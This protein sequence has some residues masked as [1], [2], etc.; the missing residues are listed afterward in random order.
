MEAKSPPIPSLCNLPELSPE[1][2]HKNILCCHHLR[3]RVDR[4][5]L[6]WLFIF[7]DRGFFR[8]IHKSTPVQYVMDFLKYQDSEA[9]EVVRVAR[10]LPLLPKLG[11]AFENG[12][13]SWSHLKLISSVAREETEEQWLAFRKTHRPGALRAEVKNAIEKGRTRPRK[14]TRG[15]PNTTVDMKFRFTLEEM[16]LARQAL[17]LAASEM[18]AS[19]DGKRPTP[20]QVLLHL[21]KRVL[22]ADMAVKSVE[23]SGKRRSIYQ[24]IY[25]KCPDCTQSHIL[26]Q[27][28]PVE[29]SHEHVQKIEVEAEK[30][31]I[32]PHELVK[33]EALTPGKANQEPVPA[34]VERKVMARYRHS[35]VIC[36]R[37]GDLHIHHLMFRSRGGGNEL[38]NLA[39]CC[40]PCHASVHDGVVEVFLDATGAVHTRSK[41]DRIQALLKAEIEEFAKV[42]PAVVVV[43]AGQPESNGTSGQPATPPLPA[44]PAAPPAPALDPALERECELVAE[45]LVKIGHR[46]ADA[47]DLVRE[48]MNRPGS[49]ERPPT[50]NEILNAAIQLQARSALAH[51]VRTCGKRPEGQESADGNDSG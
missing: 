28:G 7:I 46:K 34:E 9:R 23:G 24:V 12:E 13:I 44:A 20:E 45:A 38:P 43:K 5:L 47:R 15:I 33:G 32:E 18:M 49:L 2:V 31:V 16:E 27:D 19:G 14:G 8:A 39:P 35:C 26:T 30:L 25:Q 21:S 3:H 40:A 17:E 6:A 4:K 37:R 50:G 48:A 22:E 11:E 36:G 10:A 42:A 41:A 1:E 51:G 29:V